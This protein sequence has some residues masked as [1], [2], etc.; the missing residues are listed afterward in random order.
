MEE[1]ITLF[2]NLKKK[3]QVA[4]MIELYYKMSDFQKDTFLS[5]T[6]N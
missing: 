5:E 1:I 2:D 4:V 3:E 6:E